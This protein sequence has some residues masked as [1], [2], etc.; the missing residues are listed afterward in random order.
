VIGF[1]GN[2]TRWQGLDVLLE[3][4]RAP[5]LQQVRL[6]IA[7][8][9]AY[10]SSLE[11]RIAEFGLASAVRLLG[12][13]SEEEAAVLAQS[14]QILVAPYDEASMRL[15]CGD[16]VPTMKVLFAMACDRPVLASA[17]PK[18][19]PI[20]AGEAVDADP[21][22][23]ARTIVSWQQ[24]WIEAGRPLSD[25]PWREGEGPGR[26]YIESERTWDRT[27]QIWESAFSLID[28]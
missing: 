23:W 6:W 18:I 16:G 27:A 7:G 24:K 17:I 28:S 25:W 9:G 13:K 1:A 20:G 4:L 10:R 14:A 2:L 22:A 26:R 8:Q 19:E 5:R 12:P 3:A 15:W 11:A 21:D